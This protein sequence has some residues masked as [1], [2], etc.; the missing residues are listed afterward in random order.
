[1]S[2]PWNDLLTDVRRIA[3]EVA[4][5]HEIAAL[6]ESLGHND[7]SVGEL[8]FANI[9]A[10]A[11]QMLLEFPRTVAP[12]KQ[13][14]QSG[15][16]SSLWTET[17]PAVRKL[18]SS[19]AYSIPWMAL[20]AL[21][22]LRPHALQVSAELGS[23]LSLSLIASLVLPGGFIQMIARAGN[24][25]F[26]L[27]EPFLAHRLSG[28]LL[29]VG[30]ASSMFFAVCGMLLAAYFHVF[31]SVYLVL[32]A[33]NYVILSILWML[34]ATLSAQGISWCI[35]LVYL[36]SAVATALVRVFAHAGTPLLLM[37]WPLFAAVCAAMC[38][39]IQFHRVERK[40][41][42]KKE[43]SPPRFRVALLS[44]VPFYFYGTVYFGFLFAD[45]ITAGTAIPWIS[46]LS[47]GIDAAYKSG[48]DVVLFAFLICAALV[49]CLSESY[50]RF[51]FRLASELPQSEGTRLV[52]SLEKRHSRIMFVIFGVFVI[53]ALFAW[54][55]FHRWSGLAASPKFL[56]IV[57][58]GGVGYLMLCLAL[59]ESIILASVN[60]LHLAVRA[61]ALGLAVNL[62]AGYGLSHLLGVQYAA[63]GLLVGAA[64]VLW[65]CNASVR[66]VLQ[67]PDY[68]YSVA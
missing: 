2:T 42:Q 8:G 47:F 19:L 34:C 45:R 17:I 33:A 11:E 55:L 16:W 35:P 53:I 31:T 52:S 37:L 10:L 6:V 9:F 68:H 39:Q 14:V 61:L 7:R 13:A 20:L 25:Y 67:H 50:L 36:A 43:S 22:Y 27:Q 51:W 5:A 44:L 41:P 23:A 29:Q 4:D 59:F 65:K 56:E 54:F 57:A 15:R 12:Q 64:V 48:M 58:I 1:M 49:E 30:V 63:V 28:L 24:F 18:F 60:A 21:E 32:A 46:G 66:Q 26:G 38:A 62:L 40:Q 3:P